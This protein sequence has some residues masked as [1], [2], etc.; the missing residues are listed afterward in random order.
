MA[1]FLS[2]EWFDLVFEATNTFARVVSSV[3][4]HMKKDGEYI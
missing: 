1:K 3:P 2:K 4:C